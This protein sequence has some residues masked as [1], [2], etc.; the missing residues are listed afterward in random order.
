VTQ[1]EPFCAVGDVVEFVDDTTA[2]T[3][4]GLSSSRVEKGARY[5]AVRLVGAGWDLERVA[6]EGPHEVRLLN[7]EMTKRVRIV[8]R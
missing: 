2:E 5:R 6:G 3:F 7:S 4:D 8:A 1:W